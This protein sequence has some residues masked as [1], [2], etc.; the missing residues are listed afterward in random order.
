MNSWGLLWSGLAAIL[1]GLSQWQLIAP[2]LTVQLQVHFH[3]FFR[4]KLP[5]PRETKDRQL[6]HGW[7]AE[8]VQSKSIKA[9]EMVLHVQPQRVVLSG[10]KRSSPKCYQKHLAKYSPK[11]DLSFKM[12]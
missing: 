3:Q 11:N 5:T 10:V 12:S 6:L 7:Q 9:A 2:T 8:T 4:E 1:L